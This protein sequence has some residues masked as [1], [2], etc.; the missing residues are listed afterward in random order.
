[1]KARGPLRTEVG[2]SRNSELWFRVSSGFRVLT[3]IYRASG[4][5][6]GLRAADDESPQPAQGARFT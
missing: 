3:A 6:V 1:V 5:F 4:N 2:G